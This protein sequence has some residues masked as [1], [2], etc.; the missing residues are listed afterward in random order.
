[1]IIPIFLYICPGL[2]LCDLTTIP[3]HIPGVP[4]PCL[5]GRGWA[6]GKVRDRERDMDVSKKRFSKT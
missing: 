5:C 4:V 3:K 2:A 6:R 1:M